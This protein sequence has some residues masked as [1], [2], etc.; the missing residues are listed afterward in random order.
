MKGG[1]LAIFIFL[2]AISFVSAQELSDLLSSI[3]ESTVVFFA[4]FLVSF[5]VLFF[6]LNKIFK[7]NKSIAGIIAVV[8]SFLLVYWVNKSGFDAQGL[9]LS[10]GI[11]ESVLATVLPIIILAGIVFMIIKLK[12]NSLLAIGGLFIVASFFVYAKLVLIAIGVVLIIVRLGMML[13][14]KKP[15][16]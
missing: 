13:R 6:S 8:I 16:V 7:N 12:G 14:K 3:D 1:L 11:S 2:S 9:L 4:I 10:I 15:V 5:A